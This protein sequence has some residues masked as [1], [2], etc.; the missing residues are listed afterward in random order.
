MYRGPG[1]RA[2][3]LSQKASDSE[4]AA[5]EA[6]FACDKQSAPQ[7][8]GAV[9]KPKVQVIN[10]TF[11]RLQKVEIC[12]RAVACSKHKEYWQNRS[13]QLASISGRLGH[14]AVDQLDEPQ[15]KLWLEWTLGTTRNSPGGSET[16][17][18]AHSSWFCWPRSSSNSTRVA[19]QSHALCYGVR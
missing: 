13:S 11:S 1:K 5:K 12:N 2:V 19:S 4:P 14:L 9:S 3:K 16:I 17:V 8:Y 15:R 18:G 10:G 7:P 6:R